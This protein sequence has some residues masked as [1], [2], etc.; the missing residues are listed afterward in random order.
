MKIRESLFEEL[1]K[2]DPKILEQ[3]FAFVQSLKQVGSD[4]RAMNPVL[5]FGGKIE[6]DEAR[7]LKQTIESEFSSI[8][9]DW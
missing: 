5:E 8:E 6:D 7:E 3:V 2:A 1:K 9:G 4:K